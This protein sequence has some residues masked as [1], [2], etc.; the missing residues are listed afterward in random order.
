MLTELLTAL[1]AGAAEALVSLGATT[2]V[3]RIRAAKGPDSPLAMELEVLDGGGRP[4]RAIEAIASDLATFLGAGDTIVS[5]SGDGALAQG[6]RSSA[7]VTHV[8]RDLTINHP[9][10]P[11]S[12]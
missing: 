9:P 7:N 3:Q 10:T 4:D 8:G 12:E 1:P 2:V 5:A 6:A 11:P